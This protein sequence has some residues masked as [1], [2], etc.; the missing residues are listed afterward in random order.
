MKTQIP[1]FPYNDQQSKTMALLGYTGVGKTSLITAGYFENIMSG[2]D[3]F[4]QRFFQRIEDQIRES[5]GIPL[6]MGEAS[7]LS[8]IEPS[9]RNEF[10]V[11]D[12]SGEHIK[13]ERQDKQEYQKLI[14]RADDAHSLICLLSAENFYRSTQIHEEVDAIQTFVNRLRGL[15]PR[16]PV[17][18]VLSKCDRVPRFYANIPVI[19]S[20]CCF[21][22]RLPFLS[23]SP[24]R[25]LEVTMKRFPSIF[26]GF[27]FKGK[28]P[29]VQFLGISIPRLGRLKPWQWPRG[30]RFLAKIFRK[31][32]IDP[33]WLFQSNYRLNN[34]FHF[35]FQAFQLSILRDFLVRYYES[36][37]VC[38][39]ILQKFSQE[40]IEK[41]IYGEEFYFQDYFERIQEDTG[42]LIAEM[43]E[44]IQN[45]QQ[46]ASLLLMHE[47]DLGQNL[48]LWLEKMDESLSKFKKPW[49]QG[50][51]Q[52]LES[53]RYDTLCAVKERFQGWIAESSEEKNPNAF[54]RLVDILRLRKE[55]GEI[56]IWNNLNI[57][58][59][60]VSFLSKKLLELL[61]RLILSRSEIS[62]SSFEEDKSKYLDVLTITPPQEIIM[63]EKMVQSATVFY[64]NLGQY[65]PGSGRWNDEI[66]GAFKNFDQEWIQLAKKIELD[67]K[68]PLRESIE[69]KLVKILKK[70]ASQFLSLSQILEWTA[71]TEQFVRFV[72]L[73]EEIAQIKEIVAVQSEDQ[74]K[75]EMEELKLRTQK[76]HG[77]GKLLP[78][79]LKEWFEEVERRKA[80]ISSIAGNKGLQA[81]EKVSQDVLQG[82]ANFLQESMKTLLSKKNENTSFS[83]FLEILEIYG[84]IE[85]SDLFSKHGLALPSAEEME[86][87][88]FL[89]LVRNV[90][91]RS[92]LTLSAYEQDRTRFLASIRGS[93]PVTLE[94]LDNMVNSFIKLQKGVKDMTS[95]P[96]REWEERVLAPMNLFHRS[97]KEVQSKASFT[98]E[99]I[100]A[101][102]A[103][104]W[105]VQSLQSQLPNLSLN[106]LRDCTSLMEPLLEREENRAIVDK[107]RKEAEN[108]IRKEFQQDLKDFISRCEQLQTSANVFQEKK[109]K[110]IDKKEAL[111]QWEHFAGSVLTLEYSAK[112]FPKT[113]LSFDEVTRK[114][115]HEEA[116]VQFQ[117]ALE[118][119]IGVMVKKNLLSRILCKEMLYT[120]ETVRVILERPEAFRSLSQH[121]EKF[122][123][124]LKKK[125]F[126]AIGAAC[127]CFVLLLLY[128]AFLY[129]RHLI[130]REIYEIQT[131]AKQNPEK[132]EEI[133]KQWDNILSYPPFLI[134]SEDW[135]LAARKKMVYL[136][137]E[138][139]HQTEEKLFYDTLSQEEIKIVSKR[140]IALSQSNPEEEIQVPLQKL[141]LEWKAYEFL[142]KK[143]DEKTDKA[144]LDQEW[145]ELEK[146]EDSFKKN[147]PFFQSRL[148]QK[149]RRK[150]DK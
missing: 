19:K 70:E 130:E 21:L 110:E 112:K 108:N 99:S 50:A 139:F 107:I 9:S 85:K 137:L 17:V 135:Q 35:C 98:E 59:P 118:S 145:Q 141:L 43:R 93:A 37:E 42:S 58:L 124:N 100:M 51:K 77:T 32:W 90:I 79:R 57:T 95:L 54:Y 133:A 89:Q 92:G 31:L 10:T 24:A 76:W 30:L 6:T 116:P 1:D 26:S 117:K 45:L 114:I 94:S 40:V 12:F 41:K 105:I 131:W 25:G 146:W 64:K 49:S 53:L 125:R 68:S 69:G 27:H 4:T 13:L 86:K 111:A 122:R 66:L 3:A 143:R 96:Y 104:R 73:K 52:T 149:I 132:Y 83:E 15:G 44:E 20:F 88:L 67:E 144:S 129:H 84:E 150:E 55:I 7:T 115:L 128:S 91:Y 136:K 102:E 28:G 16:I 39:E 101:R 18:I 134:P 11:Q 2:K 82:V 87:A 71:D 74:L 8:F 22:S 121:I 127:L 34:P 46:S 38:Q 140:L 109:P 48:R 123:E 47:R 81:L 120:I 63:L 148:M 103:E 142:V 78:L 97:H 23:L 61:V 14:V 126:F 147:T 106:D 72:S 5:G 113:E 80:K 36:P 62:A 65:E 56:E 75:K 119:W 60:D 33:Q 29:S 138:E